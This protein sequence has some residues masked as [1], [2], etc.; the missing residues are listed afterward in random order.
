MR[1]LPFALLA[2]IF[3]AATAPAA[4][5]A[6][7]FRNHIQPI[8]AKTGCSLGACHGAAAGQG[9]FRLSLRGYD[10]EGDF[11]AL[12][13]GAFARRVNVVEHAKSLILLKATSAVAHKGGERFKVHSPEWETV[14]DWIAHGAPGPKESDPRITTLEVEPV[15]ITLQTGA[16]HQFQVKARFSDG[17]TQDVTRWAKYTAANQSVLTVDD[18]G[19]ATVVGHGESA[20][21][22]WYL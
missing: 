14:V 15:R 18:N 22:V 2:A 13:R 17:S 21:S 11:L 19:L 16:K 3:A 20:V 9:G 1:L 7:S 10:D 12:T 5:V 8:L 4:E 6:P